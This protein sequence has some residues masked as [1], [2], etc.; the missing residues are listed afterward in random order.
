MTHEQRRR[1]SLLGVQARELIRLQNEPPEYLPIPHGLQLAFIMLD[2][3][4]GM[5]KYH[6]ALLF[7]ANQYHNRY[8]WILDN[9]KQNG[10]IGWTDAVRSTAALVT[11]ISKS[12][13][14]SR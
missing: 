11:P 9:K 10:L 1:V 12:A 5:C 3:R 8:R 6:H 13:M 4:Y 14:M 7:Q 2:M